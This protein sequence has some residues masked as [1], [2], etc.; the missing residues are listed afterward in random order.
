MSEDVGS[1]PH[2][3]TEWHWD[4][5]QIIF[6][7]ALFSCWTKNSI[8]LPCTVHRDLWG[9]NGVYKTVKDIKHKVIIINNTSTYE[10]PKKPH[11]QVSNVKE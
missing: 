4:F 9:A 3:H 1:N 6:T 8:A 7:V 5:G 11:S 2:F 10:K